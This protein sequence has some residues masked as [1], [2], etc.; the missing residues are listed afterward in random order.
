MSRIKLWLAFNAP[1]NLLL[2]AMAAPHNAVIRAQMNH[3]SGDSSAAS[4]P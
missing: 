4:N 2:K 1:W 3:I